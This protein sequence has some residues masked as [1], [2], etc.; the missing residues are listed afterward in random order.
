MNAQPL[1][2]KECKKVL[3]TSMVCMRGHVKCLMI[4]TFY[5]GSNRVVSLNLYLFKTFFCYS[6]DD[7]D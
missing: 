6:I 3:K 1:N 4:G 7:Y 5:G 2:S